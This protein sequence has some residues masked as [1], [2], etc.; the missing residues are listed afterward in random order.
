M[1]EYVVLLDTTPKTFPIMVEITLAHNDGEDPTNKSNARI[2]EE[3]TILGTYTT[4]R[5]RKNGRGRSRTMKKSISMSSILD[6]EGASIALSDNLK[7]S[8]SSWTSLCD[9]TISEN[10]VDGERGGG[11]YYFCLMKGYLLPSIVFSRGLGC[12]PCLDWGGSFNGEKIFYQNFPGA[13][14]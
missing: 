1:K 13:C 7:P 5:P 8:Y 11:Y 12:N 9:G 4:T 6:G 3:N 14:S 10:M 2:C